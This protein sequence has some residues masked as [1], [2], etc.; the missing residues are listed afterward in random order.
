VF[1]GSGCGGDGAEP[2]AEPH[3]MLEPLRK[4]WGALDSGVATA[5]GA[6]AGSNNPGGESTPPAAA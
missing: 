4:V 6:T 2:V 5:T 1:A 3:E